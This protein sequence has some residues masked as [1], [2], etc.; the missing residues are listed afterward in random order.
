[1]A[2][3]YSTGQGQAIRSESDEST[4]IG[5]QLLSDTRLG[6]VAFTGST[7]TAWT[8]QRALADRQGP[9]VPLIAETGGQNVMIADSSAL[10]EQLVIDVLQSAFNS[11]GQRCSR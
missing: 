11:A 1:M 5:R 3:K 4:D 10:L 8:I 9:I 6:G 7:D 2:Q